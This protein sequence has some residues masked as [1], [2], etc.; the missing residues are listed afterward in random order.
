MYVCTMAGYVPGVILVASDTGWFTT[1]RNS[2]VPLRTGTTTA[3][4]V[5]LL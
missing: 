1:A 3:V 4:H 5:L 2:I